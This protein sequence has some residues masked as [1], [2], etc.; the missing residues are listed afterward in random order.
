MSKKLNT[1]IAAL[2]ARPSRTTEIST[3]VRPVR[4]T[5]TPTSRWSFP[6]VFAV[7]SVDDSRA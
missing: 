6:F 5:I 4:I 3:S 2:I 7:N 1:T